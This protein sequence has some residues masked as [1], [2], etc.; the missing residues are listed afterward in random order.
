[1][2]EKSIYS[3]VEV[4]GINQDYREYQRNLEQSKVHTKEIQARK[5][6]RFNIPVIHPTLNETINLPYLLSFLH[7]DRDDE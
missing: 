2:M 3:H 7:L 6:N 1:M 5:P 4:L